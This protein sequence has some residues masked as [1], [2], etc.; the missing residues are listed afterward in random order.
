MFQLLTLNGYIFRFSS[1]ANARLS[2][3]GNEKYKVKVQA[4]DKPPLE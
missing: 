4:G 2:C 1:K 3:N